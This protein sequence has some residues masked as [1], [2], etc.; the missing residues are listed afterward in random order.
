MKKIMMFIVGFLCILSMYAQN[1]PNI[2]LNIEEI[3]KQYKI[4]NAWIIYLGF[5]DL[6]NFELTR[7]EKRILE[8]FDRLKSEKATNNTPIESIIMYK[9]Y[10]GKL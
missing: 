8:W 3:I 10:S 6:S 7:T 2:K 5:F 1:I 4:E 9:I